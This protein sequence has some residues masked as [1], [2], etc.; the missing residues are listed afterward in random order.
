MLESIVNFIEIGIEIIAMNFLY[1]QKLI[2]HKLIYLAHNRWCW[3]FYW[4][5]FTFLSILLFL[6]FRWCNW[7]LFV[8]IT[9]KSFACYF[10]SLTQYLFEVWISLLHVR[11]YSLCGLSLLWRC[12]EDVVSHSHTSAT[13]EMYC[14]QWEDKTNREDIVFVCFCTE[15]FM[16][17][18][19]YTCACTN[20]TF[21]WQW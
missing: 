17:I 18:L 15:T 11:N 9:L 3:Y 14:N 6:N 1:K 5:L 19:L 20:A 4:Q 21:V 12:W 13:S 8:P 7:R 10:T 2:C 16:Y